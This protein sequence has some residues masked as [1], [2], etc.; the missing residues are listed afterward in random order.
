MVSFYKSVESYQDATILQ[1]ALAGTTS[2]P[3]PKRTSDF[4][5][6]KKKSTVHQR[7]R[8]ISL[9]YEAKEHAGH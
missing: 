9:G 1:L 6:R 5:R 2:N 3:P 7:L 4:S 8:E